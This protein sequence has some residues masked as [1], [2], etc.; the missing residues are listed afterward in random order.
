MEISVSGR[1]FSWGHPCF[2]LSHTRN[3][4]AAKRFLG[5]M[6]YKRKDWEMPET[7]NTEKAGCYVQA[8]RELKTGK[9]LPQDTRHRQVKYLNNRI[10][11]EQKLFSSTSVGNLTHFI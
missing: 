11:G 8:I 1:Q 7:I 10:E 5:K 3:A 6:L 9:K 2:Y 4:K